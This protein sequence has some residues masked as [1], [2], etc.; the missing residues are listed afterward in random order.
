MSPLSLNA[1]LPCMRTPRSRRALIPKAALVRPECLSLAR[2]NLRQEI[3]NHET[4]A[5]LY[6]EFAGQA[7]LVAET[8]GVTERVGTP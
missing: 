3:E 4:L 7:E 5:R 2:A 8:E 6:R 1:I